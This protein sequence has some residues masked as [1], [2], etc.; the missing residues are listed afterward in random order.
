MQK[1]Y[2]F[3]RIVEEDLNDIASVEADKAYAEKAAHGFGIGDK[4]ITH[5]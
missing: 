1:S 2:G 4:D 3:A 5:I